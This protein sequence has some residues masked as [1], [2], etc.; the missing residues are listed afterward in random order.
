MIPAA[1]SAI[2]LALALATAWGSHSL[3]SQA[4]EGRPEPGFE[5]TVVAATREGEAGIGEQP[6]FRRRGDA[7]AAATAQAAKQDPPDGAATR[8]PERARPSREAKCRLIQDGS[9]GPEGKKEAL[10]ARRLTAGLEVPWGLAFLP[11][12]TILVTER[13]GSLRR[14]A[15]GQLVAEPVLRLEQAGG[16]LGEGGLLGIALHPDFAGNRLFYLYDTRREGSKMVNRIRR[17]RLAA[18][19]KSAAVDKVILDGIPGN[20]THDG[21]RLRVGPDRMLYASTGDAGEPDRSQ[22]PKSLAGKILRLT[23]DGEIPPDNPVAKNPLWLLGVRNPQG[24]DWLDPETMVVVDHGPSGERLRRGHDELNIATKGDNLGWPP[25]YGCRRR[26]GMV[27][28]AISWMRPAPPG[29]VAVIPKGSSIPAWE[30]D[31]LMTTLGSRHLQRIVLNDEGEVASHE[32]YFHGDPPEGFGR[33][34]DVIVAPDGQIYVTTS[35]CDGRGRCP[36][37]KD[38]IL[39][40]EGRR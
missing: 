8:G 33:L 11:G 36:K 35:N 13:G 30:G 26:E 23:L 7:A 9:F 6:G 40:L 38:E 27:T 29:G 10:P 12:G 3:S 4:P 16:S 31:L 18:D 21:G 22:D 19:E 39:V 20:R 14:I 32:V 2:P 1:A 15:E 34:R 17:Y 5:I 37:T 28:P 24:F 25:I